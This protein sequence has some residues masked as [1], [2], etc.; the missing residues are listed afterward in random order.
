MIKLILIDVDGTLVGTRGVHPST[1]RALRFARERGVQVGLCTGRIGCGQ[2]VAYARQVAPDG[3]HIFQNGAVV[4][5]PDEPALYAST[6]PAGTF[7]QL[8]AISRREGQPLEVNTERG[9]FLEAETPLTRLHAAH[10]EMEPVT[11]DL[12][13][14]RGPVVS[15][16]WVVQ[17]RGW[18]HLQNLTSQVAGLD[19]SPA[20]TPWAPGTVFATVTRKGTSKA[21]ALRWL[22]A[23]YRLETADVAMIGDGVNDLDAFEAAGLSVAVGNA[24]DNVKDKATVVVGDV[25]AGGLAEALYRCLEAQPAGGEH[26]RRAVE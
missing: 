17:E 26:G 9:L 15:V 12:L 13:E 24:S 5:R 19:V 25:D 8:V 4:S 6:L 18:P 3:L 1:W 21:S 22:A 16:V 10:L 14:I 2:T 11:G 7:R 23:H 20:T